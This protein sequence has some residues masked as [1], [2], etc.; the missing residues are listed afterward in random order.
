M[1]YYKIEQEKKYRNVLRPLLPAM[2]Q[3]WGEERP[4]LVHGKVEKPEKEITFLPF[5]SGKRFI[6]CVPNLKENGGYLEKISAW[7]KISPMCIW[8]CRNQK[9]RNL[10]SYVSKAFKCAS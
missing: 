8:T 7:R 5:L 1:E 2:S 9:I 10:L 3:I 6:R 4:M